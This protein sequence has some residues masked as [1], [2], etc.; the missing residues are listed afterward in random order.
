[1]LQQI[2]TRPRWQRRLIFWGFVLLGVV[3]VL[4]ILYWFVLQSVNLGPRQLA[5]VVNEELQLREFTVLNDPE[6][7]PA[8][9]TIDEGGEV[10]TASYVHGAVFAI[11]NDG[12]VREI[13]GTRETLG[14]IVG[15]EYSNGKLYLLDRIDP[16]EIVGAIIWELDL[17]TNEITEV[18]SFEAATDDS[19]TND[20]LVLP[21]DIT[22]DESDNIY[23][24][25]RALDRIWKIGSSDDASIWWEVPADNDASSPAELAGLAYVTSTENLLV[26]DAGTGTIY[27]VSTADPETFSIVYDLPDG[28]PNPGW[29]GIAV[30]ADGSI[31]VVALGANALAEVNEDGFTFLAGRFRG[32][33]DVEVTGTDIY[34][35]NWDQRALLP[36]DVFGIQFDVEP[37]LPFGIDVIQPIS[38]TDN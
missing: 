7:Y 34:I 28:E 36:A 35:T 32:P 30:S 23:V 27:Q 19:N 13:E 26:T 16:L 20:T 4:L 22:A 5:A 24:T 31:F 10:Y 29:E 9:I 37:R 6:A 14:S 21:A 12:V 25:D 11:S 17:D 15:L 2:Q 33:S 18:V 8:S 38:E 3:F 1:M